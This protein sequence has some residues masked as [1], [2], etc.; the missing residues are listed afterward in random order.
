MTSDKKRILVLP[1]DGI[2]QDVC[3]QVMPLLDSLGLPLNFEFGDIGW[4]CWETGGDPVPQETWAKI[5]KSDAVLLGAIT[6]KPKAEAEVALPAELQNVGHKYVSPVIQL[7]Q[8][9]ELFANIRPAWHFNSAHQPFHFE[10]IREN[11]E[12]LYAGFDYRSIPTGLENVL[13]HPNIRRS[14]AEGATVSLRLQTRFGL[15][16]LFR[17]A[18][19]R[20][21]AKGLG[22]VT[23][24]DKPNVLR[25]SSAFA[26]EIFDAVGAE[27]PEIE[28]EIQNV[29]AVGMWLVTRPQRFGVIVAENM[30]GDIL[31]DVAGGVMGGLGLAASANIGTEGAYFEPVHGSAPGMVGAG[32]ANPSAMVLS[33]SL[34]LEHLGYV[35]EADDLVSAVRA[36]VRKA[37]KLTYDLGGKESSAGMARTISNLRNKQNLPPHA[38]VLTIGDELLE[39][40]YHNTNLKDFSELLTRKG[41]VVRD[42]NVIGD[43]FHD[44]VNAFR[45]MIGVRD[46]IV[47]S[48]GLGPTADDITREAIATATNTALE[49]RPELVAHI[50]AFLAGVNLPMRP[51]DR[52][53]ARVP[54]GASVLANSNGTACGFRLNL[55][56]TDIVVLPGP[57]HEAIP[58]IETALAHYSDRTG[59]P[60]WMLFDRF[61]TD[62]APFV[63]E[64][65]APYGFEGHYIW[66]FPYLE[67]SVG[68]GFAEDVPTKL[69]EKL[70]QLFEADC[71][72]KDG[73]WARQSAS[74][75]AMIGGVTSNDNA[76]VSALSD[77]IADPMK[78]GLPLFEIT[79]TPPF[80]EILA[81]PNQKT[82]E[83]RI[84]V[85]GH[86]I[87]ERTVKLRGQ[88]I[89]L[90]MSELLSWAALRHASTTPLEP[91]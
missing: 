73:S 81:D 2:G 28:R 18:L 65:V 48:G 38:S 15:E 19:E 9:L 14:G 80:S 1:G 44:I 40:R 59:S 39:G 87:L 88:D 61:E 16:R 77:L 29:D 52:S 20:A 68:N 36:T 4:R 17:F 58:M 55:A 27:F 24:A 50:K 91:V 75:R 82:C 37:P 31:S 32:R 30:F 51:I 53:Q 34:M 79:T 69:I 76:L 71:V 22:L 26:K 78:P 74:E 49:E 6:S 54:Q 12:G 72:S 45:G 11:T 43:R 62:I 23:F 47:V 83:V 5:A 85:D 89:N 42:H 57:P 3:D 46:L 33:S 7:R 84:S 21:R 90:E 10:V 70:D 41:F 66:R 64:M 13:E 8:K 63:D 35:D 86:V 67:V 60:R 56:G 25:E